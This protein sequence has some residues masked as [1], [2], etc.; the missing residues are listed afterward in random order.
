FGYT[1][2]PPAGYSYGSEYSQASINAGQFGGGD[3]NGHG[4][5]M[6]GVAAGNGRGTGNGKPA[7]TYVGAAPEADLVVVSLPSASAGSITDD[8]VLDGVRYVFQKAAALGEPAVVLLS[9]A[10]C[11]GPHDGQDPLDLGIAALTGPGKL[12]CAAAGNYGGKSQHAE[13]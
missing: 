13:W 11:T 1:A 8:K 12:V 10:K 3:T 7:Y 9:L 6:A 5:H 2:P 4:T